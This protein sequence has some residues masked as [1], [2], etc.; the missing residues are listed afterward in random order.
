MCNTSYWMKS[1]DHMPILSRMSPSL[2]NTTTC[3]H[4]KILIFVLYLKK[5]KKKN[6]TIPNLR[7]ENTCNQGAALWFLILTYLST[8]KM[9]TLQYIL[10]VHKLTLAVEPKWDICKAFA[11]LK[12]RG[13][14]HNNCVDISETQCRIG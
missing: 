10:A 9:K 7:K 6:H 11:K 13:L 5:K 12:L 1:V 8:I 4:S 14:S 3:F 2:A